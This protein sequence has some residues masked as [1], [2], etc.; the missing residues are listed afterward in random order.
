MRVWVS[1]GWQGPQAEYVNEVH[2]AGGGPP[3][4]QACE[5]TGVPVQSGGIAETTVR[6]CVRVAGSHA[7][8]SEYVYVQAVGRP[9][10][11]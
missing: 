4:V 3:T 9:G 1:F 5:R 10:P 8:Q 6:V 2:V 11:S 7:L